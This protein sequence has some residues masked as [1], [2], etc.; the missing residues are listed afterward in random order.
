MTENKLTIP[1]LAYTIL[2]RL[3]P[4]QELICLNENFEDIYESLLKNQGRFSASL[5]LTAL[6]GP[7]EAPK[8]SLFVPNFNISRTR[9]RM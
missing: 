9:L 5:S 2:K 4:P 3:V 6:M 1:R 8:M 7:A